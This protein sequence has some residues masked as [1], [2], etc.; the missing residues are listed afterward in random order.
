MP[1]YAPVAH[2]SWLCMYIGQACCLNLSTY[3]GSESVYLWY[4]RML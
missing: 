3:V 4:V 2:D 1:L